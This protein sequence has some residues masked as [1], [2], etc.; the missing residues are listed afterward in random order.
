[1]A[2]ARETRRCT[3]SLERKRETPEATF[4]KES[5]IQAG[6]S[7]FPWPLKEAAVR[8]PQ[9]RAGRARPLLAGPE[10]APLL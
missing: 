2:K 8:A 5:R 9:P 1:M 10:K 3:D 4:G 6:R 7:G